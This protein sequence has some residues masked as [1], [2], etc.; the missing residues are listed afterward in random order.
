[1]ETPIQRTM[2]AIRE[3]TLAEFQRSLDEHPDLLDGHGPSMLGYAAANDRVDVLAV[4]IAA[5]IDVNAAT[6]SATP[7][8]AA[9]RKGT[10]ET[11]GWLLDRGG[12]VN[13]RAG[14]TGSTPLEEAILE[15]RPEMARFLLGRGADPEILHGNPG[16]NALASARFWRRDDI[17]A[18]L[19]GRGVAPI[20]I[21]PEPVD[22]EA[23]G[24]VGPGD[25]R[26]PAEW[27]QKKW[28]HVYKYAIRH[29]LEAMSGRNRVL[30]LVGYLIEQLADGGVEMVYFNPSANYAPA[31]PA[32]L[33]MIGATRAA[34]TIRAINALIPGGSVPRIGDL[35]LDEID[36]SLPP[37]ASTPGEE[38][39]RI[40]DEWQP[41]GGERVLIA[42]LY[43]FY[44]R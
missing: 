3:G 38:L 31:M 27:L 13:G 44:H 34:E 25:P 23:P 2:T 21:E 42:Q 33:D 39:E 35:G 37:E 40:F 12:D 1:M 29:G 8:G 24:F 20:V 30:F 26:N 7:V 19:E 9:A 43:D 17:A 22:V 4:L 16:R 28:V 32:A 18:L 5:G 36:Q 10:V 15:G 14:S 11:V 41:D 6:S